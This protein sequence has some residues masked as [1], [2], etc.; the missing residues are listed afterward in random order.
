MIVAEIDSRPLGVA[1]LQRAAIFFTAAT[2]VYAN[3]QA[4]DPRRAVAS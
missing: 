3:T 4:L 2:G 1:K